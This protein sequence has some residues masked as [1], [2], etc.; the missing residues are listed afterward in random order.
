[1]FSREANAS[2]A[3]LIQLCRFLPHLQIHLIDCQVPNDHLMSLGAEV[4]RRE[5][6]LDELENLVQQSTAGGL[7]TDV[8]AAWLAQV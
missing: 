3:A 2:K 4:W 6:F 7:W 5:E 8:F 1:M